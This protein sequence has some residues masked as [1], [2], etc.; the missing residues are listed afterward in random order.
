MLNRRL[1]PDSAGADEPDRMFQVLE[2]ADVRK[3]I[4]EAAFAENI[5]WKL[6]RR[7]KP[8]DPY[9]NAARS[10]SI[11]RLHQR[12]NSGKALPRASTGALKNDV[13]AVAACEITDSRNRI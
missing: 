3:Y 6:D 7:P 2:S 9:D 10:D 11:D 13:S 5:Y 1:E 12:S 8:R 4:A